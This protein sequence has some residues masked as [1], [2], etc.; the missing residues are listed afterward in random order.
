MSIS[1]PCINIC[2]MNPRTGLCEGC[3]RSIDEITV[4]AGACDRIKRG[5]L[6]KVELR[7]AAAEREKRAGCAP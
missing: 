3:Y 6:D 5:I 4:W 7:R 2:R 1:S